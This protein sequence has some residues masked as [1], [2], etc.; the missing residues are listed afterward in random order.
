M[1]FPGS[2]YAPPGVYTR[3]NY[4][5]PTIG[6]LQG[7]KIPVFLAPGSESLSQTDLELVRGS[8]ATVDQQVVGEDMDGRMVAATTGAGAITLGDFDGTYTQLQVRNYPIVKGDGTGT[9]TTSTSSVS[10]T[11]NDD[12]VVVLA[13]VGAT[14]LLTLATAPEDGDTVRVPYFFNRTDTS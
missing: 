8:S 12:P 2:L 6:L 3:T 5:N 1:S 13:I 9:T 7:L 11:I 10:M 4:D 14:G